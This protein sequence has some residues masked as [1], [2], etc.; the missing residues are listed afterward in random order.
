VLTRSGSKNHVENVEEETEAA[1]AQA[2]AN[3]STPPPVNNRVPV[4]TPAPQVSLM[5]LLSCKETHFVE[6]YVGLL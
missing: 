3:D 2:I 5:Y 1:V 6:M 4:V